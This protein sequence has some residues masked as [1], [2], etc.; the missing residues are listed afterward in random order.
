M[1]TLLRKRKIILLNPCLL[2]NKTDFCFVK[3]IK[4]VTT[5]QLNMASSMKVTFKQY[6]SEG[7]KKKPHIKFTRKTV[8]EKEMGTSPDFK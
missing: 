6:F 8:L 5:I 7:E 1:S 2:V 4:K 3:F